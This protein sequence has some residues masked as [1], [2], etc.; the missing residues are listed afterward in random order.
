MAWEEDSI[1]RLEQN[2]PTYNLTT[3]NDGSISSSSSDDDQYE[4]FSLSDSRRASDEPVSNNND[5][6]QPWWRFG[7]KEP[8]ASDTICWGDDTITNG[9]DDDDSSIVERPNKECSNNAMLQLDEAEIRPSTW[10]QRSF[11]RGTM[12]RANSESTA[13]G[14][15]GKDVDGESQQSPQRMPQPQPQQQPD[16]KDDEL[17]QLLFPRRGRTRRP[18]QDSTLKGS[19]FSH[20]NSQSS[21]RSALSSNFHSHSSASIG[22]NRWHSENEEEEDVDQVVHRHSMS[23]NLTSIERALLADIVKP[24]ENRWKKRPDNDKHY[25]Q[26][27]SSIP[28]E[29]S[30]SDDSLRE[31][32]VET[33]MET[34]VSECPRHDL[35]GEESLSSEG[36]D[37]DGLYCTWSVP[38][39]P[40]QDRHDNN[41]NNNNI[42]EKNNNIPHNTSTLPLWDT[43]ATLSLKKS[44]SLSR[45]RVI[46]DVSSIASSEHSGRI[47]TNP[48]SNNYH[49]NG[50]R[51]PRSNTRD[52]SKLSL[53]S[54]F[55]SK[56]KMS[57]RAQMVLR[58]DS[59]YCR[60]EEEDDLEKEVF[61]FQDERHANVTK[62]AMN[63]MESVNRSVVSMGMEPPFRDMEEVSSLFVLLRPRANCN[64]FVKLDLFIL[65]CHVVI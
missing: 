23:M 20:D 50:R 41:N 49:N 32:T 12:E 57:S 8:P 27:S 29:D 52:T 39:D 15:S 43:Q 21:K 31:E 3:A 34:P 22:S 4:A 62:E 5:E 19:V 1:T 53:L 54:S 14:K 63:L 37:E 7:A 24:N 42:D 28:E 56:S 47:V 45:T 36:V 25:K 48:N 35:D 40:P 9:S 44:V 17:N 65:F 13:G 18:S 38:L 11:R 6:R 2:L 30:H 33:T 60:E 51:R 26:L 64:C 46:D 16:D 58:D 59:S 55:R 61:A 10:W